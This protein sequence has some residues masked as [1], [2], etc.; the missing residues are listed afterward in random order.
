MSSRQSGLL[1]RPDVLNHAHVLK[2]EAIAIF[3]QPCRSL[4][5][6][7]DSDDNSGSSFAE[8][9]HIQQVWKHTVEAVVRRGAGLDSEGVERGLRRDPSSKRKDGLTSSAFPDFHSARA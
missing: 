9:D 8:V 3:E 7:D 5:F 1:A 6:A 2:I 4:V